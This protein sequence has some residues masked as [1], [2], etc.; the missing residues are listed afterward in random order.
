[1][2]VL[3]FIDDEYSE[4]DKLQIIEEFHNSPLG[5]QQ[6]ISR[7]IKRI[8]KHHRWKGLKKDVKMYIGSCQSCQQNKSSNRKTRQPMIITT[9]ASRSFEKNVL[10]KV[11]PLITSNRQNTYLDHSR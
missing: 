1:M 4:T 10:D 2:Q 3:I 7:T 11:G 9:T 6:G 5:G 8:K